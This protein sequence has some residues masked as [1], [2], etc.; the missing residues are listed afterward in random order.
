M[1]L[2][3]H[4]PQL[5][6]HNI[7]DESF[8]PPP[9]PALQKLND[10]TSR[11]CLCTDRITQERAVAEDQGL[12]LYPQRSLKV[13]PRDHIVA[14]CVRTMIV[15]TGATE[16]NETIDGNWCYLYY[17]LILKRY[18]PLHMPNDAELT[19]EQQEMDATCK[20]DAHCIAS[21]NKKWQ[22]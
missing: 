11:W 19:S 1:L 5:A 18:A 9:P 16:Y 2:S 17:N 8:N 21:L 10:T 4:P 22:T 3:N 13:L 20:K 7:L 15:S 14:Y 12:G 6:K